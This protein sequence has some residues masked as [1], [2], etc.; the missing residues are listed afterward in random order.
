MSAFGIV[1]FF[2]SVEMTKFLVEL[3]YGKDV[4]KD[5]ELNHEDGVQAFRA[6]IYELTKVPPERQKGLGYEALTQ[7]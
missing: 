2:I 5:V 4:Y 7:F 1:I 6:K 3:K